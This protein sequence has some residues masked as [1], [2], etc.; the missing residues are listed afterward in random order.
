MALHFLIFFN[1]EAAIKEGLQKRL[2][3]S[4]FFGAPIPQIEKNPIFLLNKAG[5]F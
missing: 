2:K 1:F 5:Q 4:K 3:M